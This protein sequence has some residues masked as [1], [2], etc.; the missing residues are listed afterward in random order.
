M[1]CYS[2]GHNNFL[3]PFEECLKGRSPGVNET[4]KGG[5]SLL[6]VIVQTHVKFDLVLFY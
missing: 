6:G 5:Y 2:E 1:A 3:F 4:S